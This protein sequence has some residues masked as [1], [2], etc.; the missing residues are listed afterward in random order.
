MG[1][2]LCGP[3]PFIREATKWRKMLGGGM[4][5]AGILAAAGLFALENH[6]D[7]LRLDHDN[8]MDLAR[9]IA[10]IP[11]LNVDPGTVQTNMVFADIGENAQALTTHMEDRGILIDRSQHLR[12]V[13]HLDISKKDISKTVKAFHSFYDK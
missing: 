12:L 6:I 10:D 2:V 5:Q 8:A 7:R 4:R 13:T 1:S 3:A 11:E 9:G